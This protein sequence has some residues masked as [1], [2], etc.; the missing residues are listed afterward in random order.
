M[1]EA[2]DHE[3]RA[4]VTVQAQQVAVRDGL[5]DVCL[6]RLGTTIADR[7]RIDELL[8]IGG[9]GAVY[10]ARNTWAGRDCALKVFHS[11]A[12]QGTSLLKR[13][14]REAQ[15]ANRIQKNGRLHPN[16]VDVFDVGKDAESSSVFLVQELLQGESFATMLE[17]QPERRVSLDAAL[18][19]L[20]PLTDAIA[21][22]HLSGI[23][24]RDLKPENVFLC[25]GA[26][27]S[28]ASAKVLDFG[29]SML[30]DARMTARNEILGTPQYLPP[31][32]VYG[33]GQTDERADVWALG[34]ILYEALVGECPFGSAGEP[35]FKVMHA[36]AVSDADALP[37]RTQMAPEAWNIVR[38][39]LAMDPLE[40]FPNGLALLR[41]L[42]PLQRPGA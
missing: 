35:F 27:G 39:C 19:V 15:A 36:I 16:V 17:R 32:A 6:R 21:T 1:S 11:A 22:A 37:G 23:V 42:T 34:V 31:E 40:R 41:V 25:A 33:S 8:G 26:E 9:M 29:V 24:H 13:F 14:L 18:E 4:K 7:Y 20:I 38:R 2:K 30:R 5:L 28:P 12:H 10:R 3:Q